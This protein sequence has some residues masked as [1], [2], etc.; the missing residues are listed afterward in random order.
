[1]L[2]LLRALLHHTHHFI[3]AAFLLTCSTYFDL[4]GPFSFIIGLNMQEHCCSPHSGYRP[5]LAN[6]HP[7]CKCTPTTMSFPPSLIPQGERRPLLP[8]THLLPILTYSAKEA[9]CFRSKP[10]PSHVLRL[11][12][13]FLLHFATGRTSPPP[14][15]HAPPSHP[16]LLCQRGGRGPSCKLAA[17]TPWAG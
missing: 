5:T 4:T 10:S 8:T 9:Y 15:H 12:R 1:M 11:P 3:L 2:T 7:F 14:A 13:P 16:H 17:C 6:P